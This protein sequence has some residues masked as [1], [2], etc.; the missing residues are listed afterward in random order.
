MGGRGKDIGSKYHQIDIKEHMQRVTVNKIIEE[1]KEKR[2]FMQ[3]KG[4]YG[5][6]SSPLFKKC[7]CCGRYSI[8]VNE[9]N[10]ICSVCGWIVDIYQNMRPESTYGSNP[11]C[12]NMARENFIKYGK[13]I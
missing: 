10:A 8:P 7:A 6:N 4:S 2:Q 11:I 13:C 1:S 12:L 5:E 3:E 9:E